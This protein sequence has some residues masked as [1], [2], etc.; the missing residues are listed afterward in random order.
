MELILENIAKHVSLTPEEQAHFL[1]KLETNTY[2][3]K[4]ILLNAGEVCK[5]SYFVN[6]GI[7]RSF[8]IN[9]NIVEHVLSF[10]CQGWWMSDM[11]SF[12]SQKPGQLFI[13]VL[14]D[15]E[16]VSLS[17]ENQ[18]QLYHDIPKLERFFRILIENSL[19]ANQQRL[20]DNLSLTAEERFEKFTTKYGTL[21]HKVPQ[22]Q[23]ASFI[24]V[25]P[26]FF[27]KMKARLLKK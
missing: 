25:T 15:A 3:T 10:A 26:E 11:Y 27:S 1:S 12:F 19:V 7:L 13:E 9:D 2:K 23:I 18:E 17:K 22:K 21:V 16:V 4:T 24:G 5:H 6:S 14:E 8:N 20:M